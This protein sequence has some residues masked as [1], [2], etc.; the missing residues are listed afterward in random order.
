ME[1]GYGKWKVGDTG[2]NKAIP[3]FGYNE[4]CVFGLYFQKGDLS[5]GETMY[6]ALWINPRIPEFY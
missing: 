4:I 3:H 2:S 5:V 1:R 6:F